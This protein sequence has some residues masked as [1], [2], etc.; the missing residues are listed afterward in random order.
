MAKNVKEKIVLGKMENPSV[1]PMIECF[2]NV[3]SKLNEKY[4]KNE[5]NKPVI[6]IQADFTGKAYGWCSAVP[7]WHDKDGGGYYEVNL[8]AD[9]LMRPYVE[10]IATL[11]HEMVHL[12]N[13]KN[14]IKDTSRGGTYHNENFMKAA[15]EHGLTCEKG[16]KYGWHK[17]ALNDDAKAFVESLNLADFEIARD[18]WKKGAVKRQK[19]KQ[20]VIKY[21]CPDCG[22]SVRATKEVRIGCLDCGCDMVAVNKAEE[23]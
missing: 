15:L 17:T 20:R 23:K 8:S 22:C 16:E 11:L 21:E 5:L 9:H 3:F 13:A 14:G 7:V 12:L 4:F 6:T 1:K 10:V 2:E 18:A 19:A